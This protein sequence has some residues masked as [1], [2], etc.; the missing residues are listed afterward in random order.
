MREIDADALMKAM[1]HRAF[2]TDGDTM[3]QSGCWVRYRAIEGMDMP[4]NC[5]YCPVAHWNKLDEITGC[6]ITIG[7]KY[8]DKED[9]DYW[10]SSN[11][12]KWCPLVEIPKHGR[13]IDA[14]AIEYESID[15]SDTLRHESYYGLGI[16]AIRKEDVD[17]V[18]TV[19]EAEE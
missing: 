6:E 2:E 16:L 8:V 11:R 3:W 1:Y 7:K 9:S 19:I 18:L 13:L 4:K 15:S 17:N 12:P 5:I 10:N 14:D